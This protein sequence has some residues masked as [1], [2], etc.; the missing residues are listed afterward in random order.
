MKK[1]LRIQFVDFWPGFDAEESLFAQVLRRHFDLDLCEDPDFVIYSNFGSRFLDYDVPRLFYGSE[2]LRPDFNLCDYALAYDRMTF[3]DRYYRFPVYLLQRQKELRQVGPR[4]WMPGQKKFC[5]FVYSNDSG[6]PAR[7]EFFHLLSEY[8]KVDSGGR[9][10]NNIGYSVSDKRFFQ[11]DYRF[12][13]AFENSS[14]P[15]YS[16]EKIVDAYVAG[17]VPVYWGDPDIGQDFNA[18]SFIN[19]NDYSS[20]AEVVQAVIELDSSEAAFRKMYETPFLVRPM[21]DFTFTG[22]FEKFLVD[23]FEQDR[24]AAFRRNRHFWGKTYENQKRKASFYL[25]RLERDRVFSL[26]EHFRM[27]GFKGLMRKIAEKTAQRKASLAKRKLK[28]G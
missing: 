15:G 27:L 11:R 2:N 12:S 13:I 14:T 18:S 5:N 17:T 6:H 25:Q 21:K 9:Y 26:V 28:A 20:L 10:L 8:K 1:T 23:I 16:T 4:R 3:G 7:D 22:G 19:A 24:D